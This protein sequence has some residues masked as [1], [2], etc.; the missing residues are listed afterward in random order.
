MLRKLN[1][2]K[3]IRG[4]YRSIFNNNLQFHVI[5]F[6]NNLVTQCPNS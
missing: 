3:K 1:L 4:Y 6:K 2:R 5:Q